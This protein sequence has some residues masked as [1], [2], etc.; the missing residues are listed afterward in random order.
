MPAVPFAPF[1]PDYL[2][3]FGGFKGEGD[4]NDRYCNE[5]FV[6]DPVH[7]WQ[8]LKTYELVYIALV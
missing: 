8:P 6:F 4:P 7:G 5:A 3:A 2:F 1:D